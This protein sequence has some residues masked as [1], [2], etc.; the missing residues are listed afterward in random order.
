M[1]S[2]S[3]FLYVLDWAIRLVM[4]VVVTRRRRP[5][6]SMAW[7]LIIFFLPELGLVLYALFGS[8]RLPKRRVEKHRRLLDQLHALRRRFESHPN[9]TRP[10]LGP[11]SESAVVLAERL[12]YMPIFGSNHAE[13]IADTDD[14]VDRLIADID[15]AEDHVHLLFYI[16]GNDETGR[17]VAD[18]LARATERG[19]RCRVLVDAVGSRPMLRNL[20]PK[21]ESQGIEVLAAL[22]VNPLRRRMARI[23]LRNHRKIAVIDGRIGYTGS[24]NIVDSDYGHGD[25]VWH[26]LMLRV[27]GPVVLQLQVVFVS[28]WYFDSDEILDAPSLFPDPVGTGDMTAQAVPSGPNFPIENFQRMVVAAIYGARRRVCI[29]TPYFVPD[30]AFLQAL[31]VAV[32]RGVQVMLIVPRRSDQILVGAASRSYYIDLLEAGVEVYVH[33]DGLLHA[34]TMSIDEDFTVIGT[35]NFDIRSFQLNFEV[36]LI[37]YG[38]AMNQQLHAQQARYVESADL[39]DRSEWERRAAPLRI[40]ENIAKLLSPLL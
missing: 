5:T 3:L 38:S 2:W 24:Q 11:G 17:R 27:T 37:F 26:D 22:P 25:L 20:R 13:L 9:L 28:D 19:V 14:V 21:M 34:K 18:A 39:L 16:Y 6:S 30:E 4:L 36:A 35:S 15:A 7:L 8:D 32:L 40:F 33:N 12:A 31:Q 23:D 10:D 1:L 29:T